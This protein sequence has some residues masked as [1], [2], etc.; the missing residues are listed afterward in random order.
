MIYI[1]TSTY[2]YGIMA[3]K[4]YAQWLSEKAF[5]LN[6]NMVTCT[7]WFSRGNVCKALDGWALFMF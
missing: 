4:T 7:K 6:A 5:F 3:G 1:E 2:G